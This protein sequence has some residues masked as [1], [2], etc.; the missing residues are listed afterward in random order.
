MLQNAHT[1]SAS[2]PLADRESED[3]SE[4]GA[5]K[6]SFAKF[7]RAVGQA[8]DAQNLA[9]L[10]LAY[11]SGVYVVRTTIA[12]QRGQANAPVKAAFQGLFSSMGFLL[13][14]PRAKNICTQAVEIHYS[15]QDLA[16]LDS[17]GRSKRTSDRKMPDPF[18]LAEKLRTIGSF[19]DANPKR[20]LVGVSAQK[21]EVNIVYEA[22][23]GTLREDALTIEQQ[24]DFWKKP[25]SSGR[26]GPSF[27]NSCI[28][29]Q[30]FRHDPLTHKKDPV[31]SP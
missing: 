18:S 11:H 16:D 15:A 27:L 28:D 9:S 6:Y 29:Q 8:L 12:A 20:S 22:E 30:Q 19:I 17:L 24:Y 23:S 13:R 7:L 3:R 31:A 26:I 2:E 14:K 21:G 25:T 5:A 1:D 4:R 10:E